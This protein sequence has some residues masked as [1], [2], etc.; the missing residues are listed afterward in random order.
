MPA[1][2]AMQSDPLLNPQFR[3]R[4]QPPDPEM[5]KPLAVQGEGPIAYLNQ[6]ED[7]FHTTAERRDAQRRSAS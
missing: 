3:R 4:W 5:R 1:Q 7:S 2:Y 6:S